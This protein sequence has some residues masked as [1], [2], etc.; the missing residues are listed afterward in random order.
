MT[1]RRA[2]VTTVLTAV[3]VLVLSGAFLVR[4]SNQRDWQVEQSVL[5]R[6]EFRGHTV[7]LFDVR[8]FSYDSRA[9]PIPA[10]YNR[11]YDLDRIETVWFI[12]A[13]FGKD[14]RGPAHSFLSFGF[15]DSQFVAISM[16]ARRERGEEYSLLKGMAR[17]FE[18]MYVI[19]DER[20]VIGLRTNH[21]SDE[22]YVYPIRAS[23]DAVRKLFVE[24]VQH[25]DHLNQHPEFYNTL[26]NN[27]TTTIL[28]HA[29]RVASTKIPYGR[30]VLLPGYADELAVK[31]GL[32]DA[33]GSIEDVRKR[34]LVNERAR[35]FADDPLFSLRIRQSAPVLTRIT[36]S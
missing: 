13:P 14:W 27:C 25:A 17:Q 22:V 24:M 28:H 12:L 1:R 11:T 19:A 15:A 26:W 20:D 8:N 6:A 21:R 23:K 3:A 4:P 18:V 29:N 32:I 33:E 2:V 9:R 30:S 10:Y 5:P 35:R 34:F 31:L 36:A 16:E 7:S